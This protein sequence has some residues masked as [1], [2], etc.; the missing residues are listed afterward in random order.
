LVVG[1][2]ATDM[3]ARSCALQRSVGRLPDETEGEKANKEAF[4]ATAA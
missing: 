1:V 3:G 2:I 4:A